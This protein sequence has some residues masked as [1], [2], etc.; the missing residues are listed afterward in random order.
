MLR[1]NTIQPKALRRENSIKFSEFSKRSLN[2][3]L[4]RLGPWHGGTSAI[5]GVCEMKKTAIRNVLGLVLV[6]CALSACGGSSVS[7]EELVR[8]AEKF[9]IR[10]NDRAAFKA[11][12]EGSDSMS[13]Y[14]QLNSKI[15]KLETIPVDIC[16][17]QTKAISAIFKPDKLASYALFMKWATKPNR[18]G[19][20]R[21]GK[22][23]FVQDVGL[24]KN[25]EKLAIALDSCTLDYVN[26][27]VEEGIK[28]LSPYVDE[29][30][31]K[32]EAAEKKKKDA[33]AK[34]K[35][36]AEKKTAG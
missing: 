18:K 30:K 23:D 7:D 16:G 33:E 26:A 21:I 5:V 3:F 29:A 20:P 19:N 10:K 12:V 14:V 27:N 34:A 25:T 35:A 1:R 8:V 28:L 15:M 22:S 31:L 36:E 6:G 11:C 2:A 17:C 9:K 13:P 4:L 32:K 24:K